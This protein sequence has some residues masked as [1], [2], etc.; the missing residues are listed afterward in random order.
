VE[1]YAIHCAHLPALPVAEHF[2]Q[3]VRFDH[4]D[5]TRL[6]ANHHGWPIEWDNHHQGKPVFASKGGVR[7]PA[8]RFNSQR[9]N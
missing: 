3:L 8:N 1:I 7:I 6:A 4:K 2:G 5:W 9:S